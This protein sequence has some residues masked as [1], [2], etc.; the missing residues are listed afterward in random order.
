MQ[1]WAGHC[2]IVTG[3]ASGLG[4]A[5]A[6]RL[7]EDGLN[8]ALFDMDEER[9][10]EY[11]AEIGAVFIAVDVADPVSVAAGLERA[12]DTLG[13]PRVVVNC[14]GIVGASKTVARGEPHDFGLFDKTLRVN[15]IGNR[16]AGRR[17][18]RA[19]KAA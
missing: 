2:A 11:A 12:V 19:I 15:W 8:V 5:T 17:L 3:G 4:A 18:R 1:N 9:G 6:K 10:Q 14:A 7:S 16:Y 13:V